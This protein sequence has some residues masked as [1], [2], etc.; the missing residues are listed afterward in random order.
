MK[1]I[2]LIFKES[3]KHPDY[4]VSPQTK[5]ASRARPGKTTRVVSMFSLIQRFSTLPHLQQ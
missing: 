5:S 1:E 4:I 3:F 2:V